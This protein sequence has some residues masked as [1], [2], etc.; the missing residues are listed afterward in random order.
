MRYFFLTI[1][2]KWFVFLAGLKVGVPIWRLITHDLSKFLPS[3]LP[4]YN[5][6]FFGKADDPEGFIKCWVKHQNRNDHHWEYWIPR[7]GHNRCNPPYKDNEPIEMPEDAI[8][9]MV[10]DWLGASR[11][12]EGKWPTKDSWSWF[13]NNFHKVRLHKIT[14]EKVESIMFCEEV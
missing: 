13:K 11:A 14:R 1:K 12:Y 9:E 10:A 3:E 7:T 6:Q 2:H 4:H 5:R 8:R